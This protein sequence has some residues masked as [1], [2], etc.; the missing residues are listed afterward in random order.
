MTGALYTNNREQ[1][2][3]AR[4][5]MECGNLFLNGKCTGALVGIQPF[6]GYYMSGTGEK[7]GT[8]EYLLHFVQAKT[9]AE[10]F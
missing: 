4:R 3:Y 7:T 2:S 5:K 9:I 6:G 8:L 1:I 10:N